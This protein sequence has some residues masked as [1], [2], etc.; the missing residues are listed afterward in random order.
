[1]NVDDIRGEVFS[2]SS[3]V[4]DDRLSVALIG[5]LDMQTAP[6]LKRYLSQ[7]SPSAESGELCEFEFNTEQLFLL[8]SSAIS[9]LATW[10]KALKAMPQVRQV[11]FVTNQNLGW[12][13]RSL[14]PLRRLADKLVSVD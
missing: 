8:S 1:M 5:C 6:F 14:D 3:S 7:L 4:L 12:Q 13:R 9:C 2:T 10:L 11:R